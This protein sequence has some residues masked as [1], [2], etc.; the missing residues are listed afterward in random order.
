MGNYEHEGAFILTSVL[1]YVYKVALYQS[2]V[3]GAHIAVSE[4]Y[5]QFYT[6]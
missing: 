4:C 5:L 6:V 3:N 2:F 1:P